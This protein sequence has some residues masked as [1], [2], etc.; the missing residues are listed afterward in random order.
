MKN[1]KS[2]KHLEAKKDT[3][4]KIF[5]RDKINYNLS[6]KE[7]DWT[8]KQKE[9]IDLALDKNTKI[10]F[11]SGPSGTSKSLLSVYCTLRLLNEKK[12]SD[13]LYVRTIVE[14]ASN[15]MGTLP[16]DATEKL[17]FFATVLNDKLEELLPANDVKRIKVD[18]RITA[19]PVNYLRG[20]SYNAKAVI[21]DEFQNATIYELITAITRIG[22]FTKY[23]ILGDPMQTDIKQKNLSGFKT[24]FDV[25]NSE[26]ARAHGIHC[27]EFTKED[28]VRSEILKFIIEELQIYQKS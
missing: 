28:I 8:P 5:Q 10:I 9:F 27:F 24:M 1:K 16:G 26:K 19:I 25:F 12:I 11:V 22:H 13:A 23:F 14:S 7:L 3:S 21:L 2:Q 18:N 4:P 17:H 15:P 6:I 20:A